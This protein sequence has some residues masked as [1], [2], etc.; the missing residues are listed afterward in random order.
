MITCTPRTLAVEMGA[1]S[2][3][4]PETGPLA[5][6]L[7]QTFAALRRG[8]NT[9][10]Q[11]RPVYS[12]IVTSVKA[13]GGN[14]EQTGCAP[15]FQGDTITLCTCKHKDR[16]SPPP[17]SCRGPSADDPWKGIWVAGMCSST[18]LRPRGLFYLM[19]VG[20]TSPSHAAA[21]KLLQAPRR[22]SARRSP[23]GDI[24]EPRQAPALDPWRAS[25]YEPH[26]AGH[27]HDAK[28]REYDIERSFHGRHPRLLVGDEQHSYL[29]SRPLIRLQPSA[30]TDWVSAHHRFYPQLGDLLAL[31]E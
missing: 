1:S 6:H 13:V 9:E 3:R 7:N 4:F 12:Y 22:K 31:L 23:F 14:F 26:L 20:R 30:D 28:G 11:N 25:S 17:S 15:N 19:L 8:L 24:Y 29:W 2:Q 5:Q 21:W 16:A 10:L 27:A 18:Q